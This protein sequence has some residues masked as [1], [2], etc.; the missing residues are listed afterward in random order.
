M[1]LSSP[2]VTI[3]G[4]GRTATQTK[5]KKGIARALP[6]CVDKSKRYFEVFISEMRG[7]VLVGVCGSARGDPIEGLELETD[8]FFAERNEFQIICVLFI[9][10]SSESLQIR[11]LGARNL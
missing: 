2:E 5:K 1:K 7:N 8:L 4:Y 11:C 6:G 9:C 3:S 10:M